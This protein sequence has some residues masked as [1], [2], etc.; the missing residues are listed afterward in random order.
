M[1]HFYINPKDINNNLFIVTDEQFHYLAGVRRFNVGDEIN[2][3]D[4]LGNSYLAKITAI[5]KNSLNGQIVSKI[6][7]VLPK[8]K[9]SLYT[10]IAKGER[11]EWLIEKSAEIG[12]SKIIPLITSRSVLTEISDNKFERYR[13]ISVS[14]SSQ[15]GRADLMSIEQPVKFISAV[16]I[17]AKQAGTINIIPWECEQSNIIDTLLKNITGIKNIN[18]FIGPEG[19]FENTETEYAFKNNLHAVTLG[20]NI[21]RIETASIVAS[22]LVMNNL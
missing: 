13:K 12:I 1:P 20:K 3:F 14:A 9:V 15:C 11:F 6:P 19:G 4:G 21:L 2:I 17:V 5:S 16:D 18:I 8:I 7:F 10:A 22:V